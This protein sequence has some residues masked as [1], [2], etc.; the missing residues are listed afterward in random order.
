MS[1][2]TLKK[3]LFE[4]INSIEDAELLAAC[5]KILSAGKEHDWWDSIGTN[6]KDAI[7]KGLEEVEEGEIVSHEEVMK[8]V[9]LLLNRKK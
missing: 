1:I 2:Q 8:E 6:E 9:S 5:Y 4:L 7:K 3:S